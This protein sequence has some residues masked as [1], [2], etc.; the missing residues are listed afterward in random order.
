LFH[1]VQNLKIKVTKVFGTLRTFLEDLELDR[2]VKQTGVGSSKDS[3][4]D[5]NYSTRSCNNKS[6]IRKVTAD[7]Y[8][9]FQ[10][11]LEP[12][13]IMVN[14][15]INSL[16]HCKY[17]Q[18]IVLNGAN[19]VL[20]WKDSNVYLRSVNESLIK[21]VKSQ[22]S[23]VDNNNN[24]DNGELV[25]SSSD[26]FEIELHSDKSQA[27]A[28]AYLNSHFKEIESKHPDLPFI[29]VRGLYFYLENVKREF[30]QK[31][32]LAELVSSHDST[33]IKSSS[34]ANSLENFEH[35][36]IVQ[37]IIKKINMSS[38]SNRWVTVNY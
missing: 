4:L 10:L 34:K 29:Y 32:K 22:Q 2:S 21:S 5:I 24:N 28:D 35:S 11:N 1:F 3:N 23:N 8:C 17:Q 31:L 16:A 12:C 26:S 30:L 14:V 38:S 19:G 20:I 37:L 36:H 13:S 27:D 9:T 7:D 15:T 18:E 25:G 33:A 6:Q